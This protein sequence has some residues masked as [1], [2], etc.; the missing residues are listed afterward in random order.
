M[1]RIEHCPGSDLPT[2]QTWSWRNAIIGTGFSCIHNY[3]IIP[4]LIRDAERSK[5][6]LTNKQG[7]ATQLPKAVTFSKKNELPRVGLERIYTY[8]I[9]HNYIC[10]VCAENPLHLPHLTSGEEANSQQT[11]T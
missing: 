9:I 4:V 3:I 2:P 7:K 5:Q 8:I 6:G 1:Q 11:H 10:I